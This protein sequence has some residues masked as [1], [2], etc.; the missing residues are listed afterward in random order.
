MSVI[1]F[2]YLYYQQCSYCLMDSLIDC[3]SLTPSL[4]QPVNKFQA[5]KCTHMPANSIF[6]GPMSKKSTFNS[7]CILSDAKARM[8]KGL[9]S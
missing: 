9:R 8:K 2:L 1:R 7:V 5:D 6:S 4:P 3:V